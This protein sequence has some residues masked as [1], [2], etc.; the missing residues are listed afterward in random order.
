MRCVDGISALPVDVSV[1][2]RGCSV[3]CIPSSRRECFASRPVGDHFCFRF[4]ASLGVSGFL[5]NPLVA[6]FPF[7]RASVLSHPT[8]GA[9]SVCFL[10]SMLS[11]GYAFPFRAVNLAVAFR[12]FFRSLFRF[13]MR[14]AR[15]VLVLL[16][17]RESIRLR[18][19]LMILPLY[20]PAFLPAFPVSALA[21]CRHISLRVPVVLANVVF[22][23]I[24]IRNQNNVDSRSS[25]NR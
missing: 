12:C 16:V 18:P 4:G 23:L 24:N 7:S 15:G 13:L 2:S 3:T 8:S 14:F 11:V 21:V 20:R 6:G 9:L 10:P 1:A 22:P 5:A 19:V 25:R 17:F